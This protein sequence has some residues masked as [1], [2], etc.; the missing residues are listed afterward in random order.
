MIKLVLDPSNTD[1]GYEDSLKRQRTCISDDGT[2]SSDKEPPK[3]KGRP[4]IVGSDHVCSPCILW[5]ESGSIQKLEKYHCSNVMR[6]PTSEHHANFSVYYAATNNDFKFV[7]EPISCVCNACFTDYKRYCSSTDRVNYVPRWLK[8]KNKYCETAVKHCFMCC[9]GQPCMCNE[10]SNWGCDNWFEIEGL[11]FWCNYLKYLGYS[12]TS[13][14]LADQCICSNHLK[15]LRK[16][17]SSK[18]CLVCSKDDISTAVGTLVGDLQRHPS[19]YNIL[20]S[21]LDEVPCQT[22]WLCSTCYSVLS[23]E[24]CI[25]LIIDRGS[26]SSDPVMV[27][28][29]E[30]LRSMISTLSKDGLILTTHYIDKF[31]EKLQCDTACISKY[32]GTSKRF[33][34]LFANRQTWQVVL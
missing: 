29:A 6:H 20:C 11:N 10:I 17:I 15:Q 30:L 4:S 13:E 12:I 23:N 25:E 26:L 19:R 14:S 27:H 22:D 5:Q 18:K 7:I 2:C 8:L 32:V 9:Q 34:I 31:K 1:I 21:M 24:S 28:R 16:Y 3:K 33:I